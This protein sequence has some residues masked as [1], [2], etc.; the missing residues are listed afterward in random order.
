MLLRTAH[1][2]TRKLPVP[3]IGQLVFFW[4]EGN[5]KKGE[6]QRK[7]LGPGYVVGLRD[8]NAWVAVGG[9]CFLVAGEH[10][11]EAVVDE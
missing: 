7:W 11:S 8:G 6:S 2:R 3:K 10:P 1:N 9:R 5:A 4:R